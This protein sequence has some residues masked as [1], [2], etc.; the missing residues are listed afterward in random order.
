MKTNDP[1]SVLHA[2]YYI[3]RCRGRGLHQIEKSIH[4]Y[5]SDYRIPFIEDEDCK[6]R[7][8][9]WFRIE[10]MRSDFVVDKAFESIGIE[11]LN[12]GPA[13]G[14]RNNFA[15]KYYEGDLYTD[16]HD[17]EMLRDI[18]PDFPEGVL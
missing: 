2:A 1:D 11:V 16:P 18:F 10:A 6:Y 12:R 7:K 5:F 14:D 15:H 4:D 13:K 9:E 17:L 8:S 3:P